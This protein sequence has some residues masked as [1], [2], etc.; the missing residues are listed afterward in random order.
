MATTTRSGQAHYVEFD[1][2]VDSKI[3]K[4]RETIRSTDI[5]VTIVTAAA[6]VLGYLLLFVI[7]DHWLGMDFVPPLARLVLGCSILGAS[8][9]W[10]IW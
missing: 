6:A 4:T 5:M 3:A 7:A 10:A 2:Y 1:E 9:V 8:V